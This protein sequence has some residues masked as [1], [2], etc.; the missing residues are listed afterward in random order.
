MT[1]HYVDN[2]GVQIHYASIGNGPVI[3]MIHGFPDFWKKRNT[4]ANSKKCCSDDSQS[5]D[6][7]IFMSMVLDDIIRVMKYHV[8]YIQTSIKER[9]LPKTYRFVLTFGRSH[10][11]NGPRRRIKFHRLVCDSFGIVKLRY[12][13]FSA[14]LLF[15]DRRHMRRQL[16]STASTSSMSDKIL[17]I[18]LGMSATIDWFT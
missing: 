12:W 18:E 15:S 5:A 9:A 8:S 7:F 2:H 14:L 11:K 16:L 13:P 4:H 3:V 17:L 6:L 1:H 10:Q